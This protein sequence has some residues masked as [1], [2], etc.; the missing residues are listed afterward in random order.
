MSCSRQPGIEE[1]QGPELPYPTFNSRQSAMLLKRPSLVRQRRT[2][3]P[4]MGDYD[5]NER[6][7]SNNCE[8]LSYFDSKSSTPNRASTATN[9][10]ANACGSRRRLRRLFS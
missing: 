1:A 3:T 4:A 6:T 2:S 5:V 8:T 9:N 7:A 10:V